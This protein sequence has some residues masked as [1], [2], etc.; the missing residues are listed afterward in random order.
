[1]PSPDPANITPRNRGLA[2]RLAFLIASG[3]SLHDSAQELSI[4]YRTAKRWHRNPKFKLQVDR[5]QCRWMAEASASLIF[6]STAA[7]KELVRLMRESENEAIR[8][9][10]ARCILEKLPEVAAPAPAK[11]VLEMTDE[12]LKRYVATGAL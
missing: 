11:P 10:A 2:R 6:A 7:A 12:E 4:P 1:M 8:L 5:L 9:R 3:R